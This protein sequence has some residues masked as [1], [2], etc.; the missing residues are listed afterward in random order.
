MFILATSRSLTK[1]SSVEFLKI[2][3]PTRKKRM[4]EETA[5]DKRH[6][7]FGN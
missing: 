4:G 1:M 6:Q 7:E 3:K 5:A 2:N